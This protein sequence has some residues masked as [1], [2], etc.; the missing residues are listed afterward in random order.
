MPYP[1]PYVSKIGISGVHVLNS[2]EYCMIMGDIILL[3]LMK[4]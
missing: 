4:C 1:T 3:D 2:N